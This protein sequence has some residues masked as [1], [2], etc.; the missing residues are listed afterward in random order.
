M[1]D[2]LYFRSMAAG[3]FS[4]VWPS[5]DAA[6]AGI[7]GFVSKWSVMLD[8]WGQVSPLFVQLYWWWLWWGGLSIAVG[9]GIASTTKTSGKK[10]LD[11]EVKESGWDSEGVPNVLTLLAITQQA[12]SLPPNGSFPTGVHTVAIT[13]AKPIGQKVL[14][15]P[16][17]QPRELI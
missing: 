6:W 10:G 11:V 7:C 9:R 8:V 15:P 17:H 3:R 1:F 13:E 14:A 16:L 12:T 4:L 2:E 5:S